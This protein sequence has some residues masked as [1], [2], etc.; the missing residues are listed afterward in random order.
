MK[1]RAALA[2]VLALAA[3]YTK[4]AVSDVRADTAVAPV[5][6]EM[7]LYADR[8][9]DDAD[10][11]V[12]GRSSQLSARARADLV[13]LPPSFAGKKLALEGDVA[14]VVLQGRPLALPTNVPAGSELQGLRAGRA[15]LVVGEGRDLHEIGLRV[16]AFAL[17]DVKSAELDAGK[18]HLTFSRAF[19]EASPMADPDGFRV[20]VRGARTA[21]T[22]DVVSLS[23]K[24]RVLDALRG[25]PVDAPCEAPRATPDRPAEP[26]SSEP[27]ARSRTLRL[28]VDRIDRDHQGSLGRSLL[29]E[30]GGLVVVAEAGKKRTSIHVGGPRDT[31]RGPMARL[32]LRVKSTMFR[33]E[34]TGKPALFANEGAALESMRAD[35]DD[36]ASLW[37]QCGI[38]FAEPDMRIAP[39]P[40]PYLVSFGNDLGLPSSG[41]TISVKVEGKKV[42]LVLPAG[43]LPLD[44]ARLFTLEL[45]KAGFRGEVSR[46]ARIA[47]GAFGSAD[48]RVVKS[49]GTLAKVEA[50]GILSSD[51]AMNVAIGEVD[52]S[53]GLTHFGDM[54]SP[55][56]T[57]EERALVKSLDESDPRILRVLY[58]PYFAGGGR[59]GESFIYGDGSSVKNVVLLD[60]SGIR[61]R[62]SSHAVAHE[63]GHALLDVPGHPDDFGTDTPSLLMDSDA[64]DASVYGPRRLTVDECSRVLVESGPRGK[65]PLLESW[66][67]EPVPLPP[68]AP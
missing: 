15:K 52:L 55:A 48:V 63:L 61:T 67:F 47:P 23:A 54:D 22:V 46:N 9:D 5:P 42:K 39:P 35:F 19:P 13:A 28:V 40:P 27:C 30:V 45:E 29:A 68:L 32:R 49:D 56:G 31:P 50:D 43:R 1:P 51:L 64:S 2:F 20:V 4:G 14:R 58:V 57:L 65:V 10:G 38:A 59:V 24:G 66:P 3:A 21:P 6:S 7:V 34:K 53:D 44:A 11:V 33:A 26:V 41:G 36:A 18:T 25:V 62:R 17:E 16:V 60:R 37:A 8:D 12:D